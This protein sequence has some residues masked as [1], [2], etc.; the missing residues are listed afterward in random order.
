LFRLKVGA[1]TQSTAH[2]EAI[3]PMAS[4]INFLRA[5]LAD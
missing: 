4:A 5:M 2:P 3:D 1:V